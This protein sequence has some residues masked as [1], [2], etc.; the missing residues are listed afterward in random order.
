VKCCD[1]SFLSTYL[2]CFLLHCYFY[3][4]LCPYRHLLGLR[5]WRSSGYRAK[6]GSRK[7]VR[8]CWKF[9]VWSSTP[10]CCCIASGPCLAHWRGSGWL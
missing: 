10:E 7:N 4:I 8:R 3:D 9:M 1:V 5:C 6:C 2:L